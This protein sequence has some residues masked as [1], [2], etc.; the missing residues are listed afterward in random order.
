MWNDTATSE[1]DF[2]VS[3]KS[4]HVRT[5]WSSQVRSLVF[6]QK[7]RKLTSTQKA[8]HKCYCS[9]IHNFQ[10]FQATNMSFRRWWI[11]KLQ[12]VHYRPL[13]YYRVL[14]RDELPSH[15]KTRRKLKCILLMEEGNLKGRRDE[16]WSPEKFQGNET[17]LYDPVMVDICHHTFVQTHRPYNTESEP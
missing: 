6:S 11:D 8:A 3:W 12:C 4:R 7:S 9:F 16:R 15:E 2:M 13:N 10:N 14:K 17:T 5:T 1:D